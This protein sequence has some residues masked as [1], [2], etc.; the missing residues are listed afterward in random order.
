[1]ARGSV[2]LPLAIY[3]YYPSLTITANLHR[4]LSQDP[5]IRFFRTSL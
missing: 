2:A 1:M 4:I 5:H 3:I